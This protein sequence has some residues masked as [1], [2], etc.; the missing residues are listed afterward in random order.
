MLHALVALALLQPL[1][2]ARPDDGEALLR[3]I[4]AAHK[5]TWWTTLTFVQ[6]STWPGG[7]QPEETWYESMDR[8]G[9]LRIDREKGGAIFQS[10][11]FRNDSLYVI[12]NGAARPGRPLVHSLLVLLHDIHVGDI[13][14]SIAKL[15][16]EG[17]DLSKAH[18]DRWEGRA[19]TVVGA[20]AGDTTSSQFWVD[21]AQQVVV[22]LIQTRPDGS[23]EDTRIGAFQSQ[24]PAG[25]AESDIRF[26]KNGA[27]DMHEEYAQIKTGVALPA[28]V[29]DPAHP[30]LPDWVVQTR[31]KP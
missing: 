31:G 19:V 22:R 16:N 11:I 13:D 3:R 17:F 25:L 27:L 30:A 5:A 7:S 24:G 29:F 15:R 10:V 6:R 28:S 9:K 4:N 14:A 21:D 8:P 20:A 1:A 12:V 2:P 26:Y 18:A 23:R